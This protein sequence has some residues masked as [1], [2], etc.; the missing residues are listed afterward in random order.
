MNANTR[1]VLQVTV[2]EK[3]HFA[4]KA[5]RLGMTVSE[6]MRRGVVEYFP[7]EAHLVAWAAA[8]EASAR[9]SMAAMDEAYA[10]IEASNARI[11]AMEASHAARGRGD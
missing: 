8:A 7:N 9:R 3:R 1:I 6:L 2:Q 4:A 10:C 5:A 11:E